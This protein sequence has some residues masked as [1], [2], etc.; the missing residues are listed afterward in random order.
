MLEKVI[1]QWRNIIDLSKYMYE[2]Y[3]GIWL[4][5]IKSRKST[6]YIRWTLEVCIVLECFAAHIVTSK[7]NHFICVYPTYSW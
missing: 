6:D 5:Q 4:G 7:I 2:W 1:K 3:S